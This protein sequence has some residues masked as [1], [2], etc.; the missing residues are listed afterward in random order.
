MGPK[1]AP[2]RMQFISAM[3]KSGKSRCFYTKRKSCGKH[4][5]IWP[6]AGQN[7]SE[8]QCSGVGM[9]HLEGAKNRDGLNLSIYIFVYVHKV[10]MCRGPGSA[11]GLACILGLTN[12]HN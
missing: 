9:R 7:R 8:F 5:Q 4:P 10:H 6:S 3:K 12:P 11:C 1:D 2:Q